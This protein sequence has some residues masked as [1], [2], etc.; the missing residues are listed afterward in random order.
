MTDAVSPQVANAC[1]GCGGGDAGFKVYDTEHR[2]A[3]WCGVVNPATRDLFNM[4]RSPRHVPNPRYRVE[5]HE[6]RVQRARRELFLYEHDNLDVRT[7]AAWAGVTPA[8]VYKDLTM[9]RRGAD[10]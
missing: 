4:P 1:H 8:Q 7:I 2:H 9:I 10:Q 6:R 3:W 5:N